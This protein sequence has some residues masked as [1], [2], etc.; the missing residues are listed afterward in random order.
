V[1]KGNWK[2]C[3]I[4]V[5]WRGVGFAPTLRFEAWKEV[6]KKRVFDRGRRRE[7]GIRSELR[8]QLSVVLRDS[9]NSS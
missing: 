5:T 1:W 6:I 8:E 2:T 3:G 7:K 9:S 4:G